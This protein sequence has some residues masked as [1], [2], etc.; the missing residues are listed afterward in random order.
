M[1]KPM[2]PLTLEA[3]EKKRLAARR[4]YLL[5]GVLNIA[6]LATLI[7][8]SFQ[9]GLVVLVLS[10]VY[11]FGLA[12]PDVKGYAR[13]FRVSNIMGTLTREMENVAYHGKE[14]IDPQVL[15][16]DCLVP[17]KA[18]KSAMTFHHVTGEGKGMKIELC[19]A[20]FQVDDPTP[21][22]KAQ[23]ASGCWVRVRLDRHTGQSARMVSRKMITPGIQRPWFQENTRF[24]PMEWTESRVDPEFCS[25]APEDRL[26]QVSDSFLGRIMDL[27]EYTP[28]TVAL[29]LEDDL[30]AVFLCHRFV[31]AKDPSLK[32]PLTQEQLDLNPLPELGYIMKIATACLRMDV[33]RSAAP[34]GEKEALAEEAARA[35][36][37]AV[38]DEEI[39]EEEVP[40]EAPAET[41]EV[42]ET[43]PE[44]GATGEG[45]EE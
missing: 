28:G 11:Y 37:A 21:K 23:F 3:L 19:D 15:R 39:P 30:L 40:E 43:A 9:L 5:Y 13:A 6:V 7:V 12:R 16:E 10:L 1:Q 17:I 42:P 45:N 25:Y 20:S 33:P 2:Q 24:R 8:G 31:A 32:H 27:V 14:G 22:A 29:A 34:R 35:A 26:P 38:S 36:A 18:G 4:S 41:S 44:G